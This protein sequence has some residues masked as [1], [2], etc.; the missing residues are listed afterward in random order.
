MGADEGDGE[1]A[2][3]SKVERVLS[4]CFGVAGESDG[5][6]GPGGFMRDE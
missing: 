4:G 2:E 3:L 6:C 1:A 5:K